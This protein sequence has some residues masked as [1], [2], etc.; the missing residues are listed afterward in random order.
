MEGCWSEEEEEEG[1]SIDELFSLSQH[2]HP[3]SIVLP[4]NYDHNAEF[5]IL[6]FVLL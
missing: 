5:V 1:T 3:L 6:K 4:W 2:K